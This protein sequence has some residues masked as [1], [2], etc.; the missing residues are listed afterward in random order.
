MDRR[1]HEQS[2]L[3][4]LDILWPKLQVLSSLSFLPSGNN[5]RIKTALHSSSLRS[6]H[7]QDAPLL[8]ALR[9]S[10][11]SHHLRY[12]THERKRISFCRASRGGFFVKKANARSLG[13]SSLQRCHR[14]RGKMSLNIFLTCRDPHSLPAFRGGSLIS[15]VGEAA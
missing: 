1:F 13:F 4:C 11:P 3:P 8:T 7:V 10:I 5:R 9:L 14:I 6:I 12:H 15:F 2:L